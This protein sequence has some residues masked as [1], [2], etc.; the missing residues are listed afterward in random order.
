MEAQYDVH[1]ENLRVGTV[2]LMEE[3]LYCRIR[4]TCRFAKQ[5]LYDL[6]AQTDHGNEKLGLLIPAGSQYEIEMKIPKK[7]LGQGNVGFFAVPRNPKPDGIFV[8]LD[9][10]APF[11][12]IKDLPNGRFARCNGEAGILFPEEK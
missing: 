5:E 6:W 2:Q 7:R 9:P 11:A 8:K 12:R 4:C 1:M 3:G 10:S